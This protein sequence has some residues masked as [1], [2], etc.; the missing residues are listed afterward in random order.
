[1]TKRPDHELLAGLPALGEI[2]RLQVAVVRILTYDNASALTAAR[3]RT[4]VH[5]ALH[6]LAE[7]V[8]A[9][10]PSATTSPG[11]RDAPESRGVFAVPR[12]LSRRAPAEGTAKNTRGVV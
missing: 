9:D 1:M 3:L 6:R 4:L 12:Q 8:S 11:E 5:S 7:S 10:D 2:D